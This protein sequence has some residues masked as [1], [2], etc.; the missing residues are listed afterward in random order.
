MFTDKA[1][2]DDRE[3][4][5][6]YRP[7]LTSIRDIAGREMPAPRDESGQIETDLDACR[8]L[9]FAVLETAMRDYEFMR[10]VD[11]ESYTSTSQKKRRAGIV[12]DGDPHEFFAGS[13]YRDICFFL[14]LNPDAVKELLDRRSPTTALAQAS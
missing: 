9:L 13:W 5:M 1:V 8:E 3:T 6:H 12:E 11:A 10:H 4:D 2:H 7:R 14:D